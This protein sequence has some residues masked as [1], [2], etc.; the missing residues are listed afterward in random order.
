MHKTVLLSIRFAE[1]ESSKERDKNILLDKPSSFMSTDDL[2]ESYKKQLIAD[3]KTW[4]NPDEI[5]FEE[6]I[7][8]TI[9]SYLI[10]C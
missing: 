5:V 4:K 7:K 6:T 9:D 2:K 10:F 1:A 3:S 8:N